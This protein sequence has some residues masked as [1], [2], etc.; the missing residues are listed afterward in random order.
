M[1]A[2]LKEGAHGYRAD[3]HGDWRWRINYHRSPNG[4]NDYHGAARSFHLASH[5]FMTSD[6]LL[7][8]MPGAGQRIL[9]LISLQRLSLHVVLRRGSGNRMGSMN[10]LMPATSRP[11][12]YELVED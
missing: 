7:E 3:S 1:M 8:I 5:S 9:T 10:S 2:L 12:R 6:Q 11:S 4:S